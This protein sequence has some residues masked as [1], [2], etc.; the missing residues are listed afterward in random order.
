VLRGRR[1]KG[2]SPGKRVSGSPSGLAREVTGV[3]L[4]SGSST[5]SVP[6]VALVSGLVVVVPDS[7]AFQAGG[8]FSCCEAGR[9]TRGSSGLC[10]LGANEGRRLWKEGMAWRRPWLR[11]EIA[12]AV[13]TSGGG[14]RFMLPA[15]PVRVIGSKGTLAAAGF[16][17]G[18]P[19]LVRVIGSTGS[20]TVPKGVVTVT[21]G[22]SAAGL[23]S[24]GAAVGLSGSTRTTP[25]AVFRLI[26]PLPGREE[27][28]RLTG[29]GST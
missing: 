16:R 17:P 21:G 7:K 1:A 8:K 24:I 22:A 2:V 5:A 9:F 12:S 29:P 4:T 27:L 23:V 19:G 11:L 25:A 3:R 13:L 26:G 18:S 15:G 6:S 10:A 20:W 14:F 28:A